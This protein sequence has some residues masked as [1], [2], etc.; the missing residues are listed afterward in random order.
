MSQN[1]VEQTLQQ[2]QGLSAGPNAPASE[3]LANAESFISQACAAIAATG[4]PAWVG[5]TVEMGQGGVVVFLW[6]DGLRGLSLKVGEEGPGKWVYEPGKSYGSIVALDFT[7]R[8]VT[9]EAGPDEFALRVWRPWCQ[10]Q[11][12]AAV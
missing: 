4:G 2:V 1:N 9:G 12:P 5:P 7:S 8:L 3:T 10:G 6:Q 11:E